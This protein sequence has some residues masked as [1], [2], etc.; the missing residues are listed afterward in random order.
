M[1]HVCLAVKPMLCA[2][3]A[4]RL[5]SPINIMYHERNCKLTHMSQ[6]VMWRP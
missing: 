2:L 5:D 4:K 6:M 1:T 3:I